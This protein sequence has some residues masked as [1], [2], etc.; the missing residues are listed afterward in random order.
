MLLLVSLLIRINELKLVRVI[1]ILLLRLVYN[2]TGL[3]NSEE[4]L[5]YKICF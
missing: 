3:H 1:Q 2:I 4:N 5:D